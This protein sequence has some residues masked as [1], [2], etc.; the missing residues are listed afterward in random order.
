MVDVVCGGRRTWS[1]VLYAVYLSV[2][3][4]LADPKIRR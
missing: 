1:H 4:D 3:G 2:G